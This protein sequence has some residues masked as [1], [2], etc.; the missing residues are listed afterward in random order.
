MASDV[1]MRPYTPPARPPLK[2]DHR[3]GGIL[4]MFN[5]GVSYT[6]IAAH[7]GMSA[8]A[9]STLVNDLLPAEVP[10]MPLVAAK[11]RA[12]GS[13]RTPSTGRS[14]TPRTPWPPRR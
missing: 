1:K 5:D 10:G 6:Q 11:T 3:T 7:Y 12:S 14:T 13:D 9:V 8:S 2:I 4:E